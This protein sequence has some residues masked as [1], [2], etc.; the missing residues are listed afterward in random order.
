VL[1]ALTAHNLLL[2]LC[3]WQAK[4]QQQRFQQRRQQLSQRLLLLKP[5]FHRVLGESRARLA[6]LAAQGP[7][8]PME[9][10]VF[11]LEALVDTQQ[12]YQQ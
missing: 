12:E 5:N 6:Q 2:P 9:E 10:G 11:K 1:G 8:A 7:L 4:A 3:S